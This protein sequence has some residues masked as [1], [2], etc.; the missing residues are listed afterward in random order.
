[1]E[2]ALVDRGE[3]ASRLNNVIRSSRLPSNLLGLHAIQMFCI[4]IERHESV[5]GTCGT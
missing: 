2:L 4:L 3:G 5:G 1:M